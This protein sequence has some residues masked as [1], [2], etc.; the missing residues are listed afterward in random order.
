M[1][2]SEVIKRYEAYCLP[3]LSAEEMSQV[4]TPA[5]KRH[6]KGY[7]SLDIREQTVAEAIAHGVDLII[8]SMRRFSVSRRL[9]W[10][11]WSAQ[12]QIYIDL[13]KHDIAVYV[14]HTNIDIVQEWSQRLV[15]SSS[16]HWNTE[17]LRWQGR[18]WIGRIGQKYHSNLW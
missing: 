8:V 6:P 11:S 17:P 10:Y 12:N 5:S 18:T 3:E 7:G 2:A 15:L 4:G 13:I 1:L 9:I 16:G 14:S